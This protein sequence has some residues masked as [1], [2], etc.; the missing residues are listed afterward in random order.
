MKSRG[1]LDSIQIGQSHWR[2]SR[3]AIPIISADRNSGIFGAGGATTGGGGVHIRTGASAIP[4]RRRYSAIW[5]RR[6]SALRILR[7]RFFSSFSS[8]LIC[9]LRIRRRS[10]RRAEASILGDAGQW[11][12]K[13]FIFFIGLPKMPTANT[14]KYSE[15]QRNTA[16][17]CGYTVAFFGTARK[18]MKVFF[19]P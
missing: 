10:A 3:S 8:G 15:I 5:I 6:R 14:A 13:S 2:P 16:V 12:K 9:S 1:G 7:I 17:R 4:S 11:V 18:K 19:P